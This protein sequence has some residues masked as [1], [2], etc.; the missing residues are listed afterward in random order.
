MQTQCSELGFGHSFH[1]SR[2]QKLMAAHLWQYEGWE[3]SFPKATTHSKIIIIIPAENPD[4]E[5]AF[6]N[7]STTHS[8]L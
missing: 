4:V 3:C 1:F 2:T 8:V 7:P 6:K 5:D